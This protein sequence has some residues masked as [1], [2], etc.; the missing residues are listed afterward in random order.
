MRKTGDDATFV[1]LWAWGRERFESL[2][3]MGRALGYTDN[4]GQAVN[5]WKRRGVPADAI[6]AAQSLGYQAKAT[7]RPASPSTSKLLARLEGMSPE[8]RAA[9]EL[10]ALN[11]IE[12]LRPS[13]PRISDEARADWAEAKRRDAKSAGTTQK[14]QP[15]RKTRAG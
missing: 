1:A 4:P 15:A 12:A 11:M 14:R 9:F 2:A 7:Q 3:A 10:A 8:M 13:A 6:L 5:N